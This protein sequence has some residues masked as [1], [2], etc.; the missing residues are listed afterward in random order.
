[1]WD[2]P[3]LLSVSVLPVISCTF[4][5]ICIDSCYSDVAG[6]YWFTIVSQLVRVDI[7]F[8]YFIILG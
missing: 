6:V 8:E 3:W 7:F 2:V 4:L 1:M 5:N